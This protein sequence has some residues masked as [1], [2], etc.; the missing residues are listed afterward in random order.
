MLPSAPRSMSDPVTSPSTISSS[1]IV[2]DEFALITGLSFVPVIVTVTSC[3]AVPPCPSSTCTV[4][5]AFTVSPSPK[6]SSS[7]SAIL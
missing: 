3:V 6:K 4:N 2:S 7:L 1:S 5:L